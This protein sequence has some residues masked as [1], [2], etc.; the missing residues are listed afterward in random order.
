MPRR[1]GTRAGAAGRRC[2]HRTRRDRG[3]R[4]RCPWSGPARTA[5]RTTTATMK[6]ASRRRRHSSR[7]RCRRPADEWRDVPLESL[8]R[9]FAIPAACCCSAGWASTCSATPT[10][11][12]TT[13][14]SCADVPARSRARRAAAAAAARRRRRATPLRALALAG[15]ELPAGAFGDALLERE[16][17]RWPAF[18][19]KLR[20]STA[21]PCLR[22]TARSRS[23][24]RS[25]A[26]AGNCMPA[27]PT[28]GA[29]GLRALALRR[30][31]RRATCST[32]GC[33][34]CC[35]APA[36]PTGVA[37]RTQLAGARRVA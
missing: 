9:F 5:P 14:P 37:L 11:C 33:T 26:G 22:T 24:S 27:S 10:N 23:I 20:T 12:R 4:T 31:A 28:C 8:L 18:A 3:R 21:E 16:V 19:G 6:P 13:S 30:S 17:E 2:R 36:A 25:T 32:P 1:C 29:G 35:C 7:R 34:T 15:T